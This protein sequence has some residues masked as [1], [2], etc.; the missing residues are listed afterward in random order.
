[1]DLVGQIDLDAPS[2]AGA[3][4]P[5]GGLV[6]A[7]GAKMDN[8]AYLGLPDVRLDRCESCERVWLDA[9]E[10]EL[11]ARTCARSEAR[12]RALYEDARRGRQTYVDNPEEVMRGARRRVERHDVWELIEPL[13]EL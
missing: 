4:D 1:R 10:L 2:P 12:I 8:F 7:C 13:F 6:C 5:S 3:G 11:V 9:E